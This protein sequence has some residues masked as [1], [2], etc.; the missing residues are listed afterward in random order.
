MRGFAV[1]EVVFIGSGL[2]VLV[3]ALE[4]ARA[5]LP[6]T[7][8]CD[9]RAPGG[10]FAGVVR[11]GHEFD[12]GMV[13]LEQKLPLHAGHPLRDYQPAVRN[14]WTRFGDRASAWLQAQADLVR[15]PTPTLLFQG[16]PYPDPL[17]ANRLDIL[18]VQDWPPAAPLADTDPAHASRKIS[19]PAYDA[20][21]FEEASRLNHG[22]AVHEALF[23]PFVRKLA[24]VECDAIMARQH[25]ALWVPLYYPQTIRAAL[26]GE[27]H[28]LP[29][30]PFWTPSAGTFAGLIRKLCAELSAMPQVRIIESP[31]TRL[32]HDQGRWRVVSQAGAACVAARLVMGVS[33]ERACALLGVAAPVPTP[34]ASISVLMATVPRDRVQR[35][36]ACLMTG[37]DSLAVYRMTCPDLAAN[38]DSAQLRWVVEARPECL[39]QLHPGIEPAAALAGELA[40]LA[41]IENVQDIHVH[42]VLTARNALVLP[43][44]AAVN[45]AD[46]TRQT[47]AHAAPDAWMTGALLGYGVASINDQIVQ[48]LHLIEELNS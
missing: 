10:H 21:S 22:E 39:E 40:R 15:V 34:A 12:I 46:L 9:G 11:N 2:A 41:G 17:I 3:A 4:R 14:D 1:D 23:A 5:G 26:A 20:L 30:Y 6:V 38:R 42:G 7:L 47:L 44:R 43:T 13:F 24:G 29:E 28:G 31:I 19:S 27:P 48:G 25:R 32:D 8:L 16:T 45:A 33:T 18:A 37:D 35:P 36:A